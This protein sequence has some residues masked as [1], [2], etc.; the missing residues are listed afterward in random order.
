[1]RA[2]DQEK[3]LKEVIA[4]TNEMHIKLIK[5]NNNMAI[6]FLMDEVHFGKGIQIVDIQEI[7]NLEWL[8]KE[9]INSLRRKRED[10]EPLPPTPFEF[11][12]NATVTSE[13]SLG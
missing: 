13:A 1:M 3:Y 11:C 9:K 2:T 4:K 12:E 10:V 7:C 6:A 8:L 5:K